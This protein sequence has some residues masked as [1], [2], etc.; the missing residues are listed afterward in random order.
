MS[1]RTF[2]Q[3]FE[4]AIRLLTPREHSELELRRKLSKRKVSHD[5]IDRVVERL[6]ELD[7]LSDDR[8]AELYILQRT[9]RGDGPIKIRSNLIQRGIHSLT[10]EKYLSQDDEHWLAI[11]HS[12]VERRLHRLR[13]SI[14]DL[15][16]DEWRRL[17]G[18]LGSRGFP[19]HLARQ[20]LGEVPIR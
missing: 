20:V 2:E 17:Y 11:A 3:I 18:F 14:G 10:I 7:Y 16:K 5:L 1:E 6:I 4:Q 12:V 19:G 15:T 8:F 9:Q 13:K